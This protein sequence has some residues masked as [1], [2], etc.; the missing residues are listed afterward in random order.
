MSHTATRA[1]S[2]S[3]LICSTLIACNAK[4][5]VSDEPSLECGE[6]VTPAGSDVAFEP[7]TPFTATHPAEA[8]GEMEQGYES[9]PNVSAL[10]QAAMGRWMACEFPTVFG[11]SDEVGVEIVDT[12]LWY[13]LYANENGQIVRGQGFGQAGYWRYADTSCMNE[14]GT[15]QIDFLGAPTY[16]SI[17][18]KF[19]KG[20]RKMLAGSETPS[21]YGRDD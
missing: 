5:V 7:G 12:G 16:V 18:P 4:M 19:S 8:C 20:P 10:L 3:A 13:K 15:F 2:T 1:L 9:T 17:V 21:M 6:F 11:T 14:P